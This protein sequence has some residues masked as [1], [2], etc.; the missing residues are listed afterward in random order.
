MKPT[1]GAASDGNEQEREDERSTF[2]HQVEGRCHN[3]Q[4]R[5][6]RVAWYGGPSHECR[7]HKANNDQA[8]SSNK[9]QGVNEIARLQKRPD[10]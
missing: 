10:R 1:Y 2:R 6:L 4:R 9:L 7:T 5:S 8:E 3:L